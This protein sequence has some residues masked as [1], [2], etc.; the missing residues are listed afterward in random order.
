MNIT[1]AFIDELTHLSKD[2]YMSILQ[3]CRIFN[4]NPPGVYACT[5]P[6]GKNSWVYKHF[7]DSRID[8]YREMI[9]VSSWSNRENLPDSYL[10]SLDRL[11]EQDRKKMLLGEWLNSGSCVFYT[12]DTSCHVS[13]LN[14]WKKDDYDDY[15]LCNDLGGGAKYSGTSLIGRKD[16][17]YYILDEFSKKKTTHKE[18]LDWLEKYRHL[19]ELVAYD[20]ANAVL[21]T[22]L[23]NN[24]WIP[25]KPNKDIEHGVSKLNSLFAENRIVINSKC[26]TSIKQFQD[27]YRNPETDKWDKNTAEIDMIDAIRYGILCFDDNQLMDKKNGNGKVFVFAL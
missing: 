3:R 5:N 20:P 26:Q 10:K 13:N 6:S 8:G 4:K 22:D 1:A 15:I 16:G 24:S 17:R 2:S 18:V 14:D 25:M 11:P 12:F 19:T 27:A 23:E 7:E 21:L 9:T